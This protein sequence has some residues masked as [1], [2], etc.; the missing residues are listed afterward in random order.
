[1]P[2]VN[3][4]LFLL[5]QADNDSRGE[6]TSVAVKGGSMVTKE[7]VGVLPILPFIMGD[8]TLAAHCTSMLVNAD[9]SPPPPNSGVNLFNLV[10][11]ADASMNSLNKIQAI[12]NSVQPLR[13]FNKPSDVLKTTRARL[14]Q[15]LANIPGCIVP[16]TEAADPKTF[17]ELQAVC[18]K[19]DHWPM[20][21]RARGYHGGTHMLL[22][23]EESQL[24]SLKDLSWPYDGICLIQFVDCRDKEGIYHKVR[25]V[26]VDG[27]AYARQCIYSD[28]W[29]IHAG[30]RTDLMDQN[31]EL[32]HREKNLLAQ[33][34]D[35][36][37]RE[38]EQLFQEVYQ[39]IGLD[40]FGIDLAMVNDQLIIFE[41]NACMHF[42]G[43]GGG[44]NVSNVRY[45][46]LSAY[47][48]ELR[49][50]VKKM[51]VRAQ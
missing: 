47:K 37:L 22:L 14:P 49:R 18:K 40:V 4:T 32:C 11:D 1:M 8:R 24:Q 17:A 19:F 2:Y 44:R 23:S 39:R 15:T 21:I 12:I 16:R 48:R 20:I 7:L 3:K 27:V 46:Y 43:R 45:D 25:V 51:L 10:G 26:M 33:L 6:T 9:T 35:N 29:A 42:L 28:R 36:G 31:I 13:C 38:R 34:R 50:A 41:A 5:G 30:S